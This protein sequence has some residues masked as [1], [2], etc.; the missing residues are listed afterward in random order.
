VGFTQIKNISNSRLRMQKIK[1]NE[2]FSTGHPQML[3]SIV[4]DKFIL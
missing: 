4:A 2:V 1:Q 3:H